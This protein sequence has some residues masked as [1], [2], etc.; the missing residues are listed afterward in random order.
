MSTATTE[1]NKSTI[2]TLF[3]PVFQFTGALIKAN[4]KNVKALALSLGLPA[5]MLFTFWITTR[6]PQDE[7]FDL[8]LYMFPAIVALAVMM[9]GLAQT[10][11]ISHWREQ[12]ILQR[13]ALTPV[14]LSALVLGAA[15]AQIV[16]GLLQGITILALG[17]LIGVIAPSI[18]GL[19]IALGMMLISAITF[20]AYGSAIATFVHRSDVAG[21]VFFFT[22]L[23]IFFLGSFPAEMLP[24][25]MQRIIVWLPTTM[26]IELIGHQIVTGLLPDDFLF[27][28]G[29][30]ISYATVCWIVTAAFFKWDAE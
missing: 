6:G 17:V 25:L 2:E 29:G 14:P 10:T 13:F 5:F 7:D 26:A 24:D 20:V 1:Y 4:F 9:A 22:F 8:M 21:Y 23:P 11:R 3:R 16:T 30:L 15:I 28:I 27:F 19:I 12:G 18:S